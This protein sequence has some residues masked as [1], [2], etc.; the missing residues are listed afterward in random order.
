VD[1]ENYLSF[2]NYTLYNELAKSVFYL[3]LFK[4]YLSNLQ[5]SYSVAN[6]YDLSMMLNASDIDKVAG[7]AFRLST[8]ELLALVLLLLI[9][10]IVVI[11]ISRTSL[12]SSPTIILPA[13]VLN[14]LN[15]IGLK[16]NIKKKIIINP[17]YL[18]ISNNFG[19]RMADSF[20]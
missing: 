13:T 14:D 10:I 18:H 3:L 15:S 19:L 7:A 9:A 8:A 4:R 2:F 11:S 16:I 20:G 1:I 12:I 5:I 17:L 6:S